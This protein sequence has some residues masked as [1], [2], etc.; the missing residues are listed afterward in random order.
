M[1]KN[2]INIF[3]AVF[4]N[5]TKFSLSFSLIQTDTVGFDDK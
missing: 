2:L 1:I 4:E 3:K 5:E